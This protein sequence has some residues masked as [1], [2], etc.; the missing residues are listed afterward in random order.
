[1]D[2]LSKPY[3]EWI[4]KSVRQLFE[5]DP[6]AIYIGAIKDGEANSLVWKIGKD[7]RSL[8]IQEIL[9]LGVFETIANSRDKIVQMLFEA[10]KDKIDDDED[11]E[12]W[13]LDD[14][15]E[16]EDE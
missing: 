11:E 2:Y 4:D 16:G 13:D 9:A 14:E 7:E 15:E 12:E 3:A 10:L 1:M 8:L 5:L 6:D